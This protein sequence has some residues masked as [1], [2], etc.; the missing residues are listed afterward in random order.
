V[1]WENELVL[2]REREESRQDALALAHADNG[3]RE[4]DECGEWVDEDDLASYQGQHLCPDCYRG[5]VFDSLKD[6]KSDIDNAFGNNVR[7]ALQALISA[8]EKEGGKG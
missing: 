7:V 2:E 3:E 5:Y 6:L 8:M 1:D 4:C